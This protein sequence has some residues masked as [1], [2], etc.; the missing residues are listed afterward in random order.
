MAGRLVVS[1]LLNHVV[2]VAP[3]DLGGGVQRIGQA[4]RGE[5]A[6]FGVGRVQEQGQGRCVRLSLIRR[7]P[8]RLRWRRRGR[9]SAAVWTGSA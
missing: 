2:A 8:V 5:C 7:S 4:A 9:R 6:Q 1:W 3:V